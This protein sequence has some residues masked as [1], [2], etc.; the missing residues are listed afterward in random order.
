MDCINKLGLTTAS[1]LI[2]QEGLQGALNDPTQR[3]TLFVPT[4]AALSSVN[5]DE[6][7][8]L[9]AFLTSHAISGKRKTGSLQGGQN[10]PSLAAGHFIHITTVQGNRKDASHSRSGSHSK[11]KR[12]VKVNSWIKQM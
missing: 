9:N 11:S 10:I 1:D 7:D 12:S 8:D 4:N 2:A 3:F 6:V 5:I